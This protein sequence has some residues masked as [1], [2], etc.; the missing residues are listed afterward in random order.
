[1]APTAIKEKKAD[2]RYA[3]TTPLTASPTL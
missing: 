2:Q 1:M 3:A